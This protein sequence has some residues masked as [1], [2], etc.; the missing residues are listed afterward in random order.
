MGGS[1]HL[2]PGARPGR[3]PAPRCVTGA[4]HEGG[5]RLGARR[6]QQIGLG[7]EDDDD[8][9]PPVD[10]QRHAVA[11]PVDEEDT[12]LEGDDPAHGDQS[13]LGVLQG[14]CI[15]P[16]ED[17]EG[18]NTEEERPRLAL[19]GP[20][21]GGDRTQQVDGREQHHG[22]DGDERQR[23]RGRDFDERQRAESDHG[24]PP[25]PGSGW[26]DGDERAGRSTGDLS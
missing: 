12:H 16:E 20:L 21:L 7:D 4:T 3:R 2:R 9:D 11:K 18:D 22:E 8:G 1:D 17:E 14:R 5:G 25:L 19:D 26:R 23:P 10:R 6:E 15:D 24:A 13:E